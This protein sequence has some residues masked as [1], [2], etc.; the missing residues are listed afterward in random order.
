MGFDLRA[1]LDARAGEGYR[2]HAEHLN[3]QV[4]KMLHAIGFDKVFTRAQGTH[5]WDADGNRYLDFL[6][7]F[8]VHA[9]GRNHPAVRQALH[10]VL[11]A[12]LADMVQFDTPVLPGLLAEKLLA[13]A[14]GMDRVYFA[15][16]GAEA[17]EAAL[18]FARCATGKPRVLFCDH[19]YHGLTAGALSV[20][21]AAE[22]RAGFAPL[23]P[24]TQIPFGDLDAL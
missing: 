2:L 3:A 15:N 5:L 17:V 22:F 21:G 10:E 6:S 14:P 20:N 1:V 16:S 23:L 13:H 18:K 9:L 8:G 19:A 11:D 12:E 24:D 7:G 4:P